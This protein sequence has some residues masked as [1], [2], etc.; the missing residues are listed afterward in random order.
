MVSHG[1]NG[2]DAIQSINFFD[3]PSEV[4]ERSKETIE[5]YQ[6]KTFGENA[7][8]VG[9]NQFDYDNELSSDRV[10]DQVENSPN[11]D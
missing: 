4:W 7:S 1:I 3:D 10:T 5:K 8:N 9:N 2:L 6:E 11:I